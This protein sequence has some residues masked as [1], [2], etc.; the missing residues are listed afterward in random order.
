[1][2][3]ERCYYK[4][5]WEKF[6]DT[7]LVISIF[8]REI[9]TKLIHYNMHHIRNKKYKFTME[10]LDKKYCSDDIEY[11]LQF[12]NF[13]KNCRKDSNILAMSNGMNANNNNNRLK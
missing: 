12:L 13:M 2:L 1:M 5:M 11:L 10:A 8:E 6:N 3:P 4:D 7:K 9:I